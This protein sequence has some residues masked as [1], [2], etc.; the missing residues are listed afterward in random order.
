MNELGRQLIAAGFGGVVATG[1][2]A[3]TVL[4]ETPY[5]EVTTGQWI[6]MC[7]LGAVA[8]FGAWKTLLTRSPGQ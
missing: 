1:N 6:V 7:V 8:A 5:E 2:A 3:I 4:M